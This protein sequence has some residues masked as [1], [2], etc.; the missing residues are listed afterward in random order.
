MTKRKIAV[1][2]GTRADYGL[3][4]WLM[5]EIDARPDLQLQVVATGMHFAPDFGNT[6]TAILD[7]G[8]TIDERVEMLL[9]SDSAVGM[10]KSTGLGTIGLADALARLGP[11]VV[12]I[13]GDRF[14]ALAAAQTALLMRIPI[15]HIAGGEA[16][17]G[18]IDD[19]IRHA[20]T[21]MSH[22]HFTAAKPYHDRVVQMGEDPARVFTVGGIGLDN[23]VRMPMLGLDE[24]SAELDWDLRGP[25]VLCTFHP[26]TLTG[27][28]PEDALRPLFSAFA[29]RPALRILFTKGNA[30]A[31]G[32]ELNH[33]VDEFVHHNPARA[34]AFTSLG[35]RR[36]LS[37]LRLANVV[38]GNS[39]SGIAE[40]PSAGTPTVNI[41]GRQ[42]GRL[43]APSVI[44][45]PNDA[46]AIGSA[47]D[48][49]LTLEFQELAAARQSPFGAPGAS[50]EIA[51]VLSA[52][53]LAPLLEKTFHELG[54]EERND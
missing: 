34:K 2:T 14:E 19:S 24:L 13:L 47:I 26:E 31:G 25:L 53:P 23:F 5:V 4:R 46:D 6:Y 49:S 41:G 54:P 33:L 32:R 1:V 8:F 37:V 15:A 11:D 45:T 27:G 20:I 38:V 39:S 22:L 50:A 21:K 40:A 9:A 30:D 16:T 35:Q 36:Y 51:D 29:A 44:D 7:D 43:R 18:A 48:R 3:L 17:E 52:V 28:S 10:A 42:R 12:V